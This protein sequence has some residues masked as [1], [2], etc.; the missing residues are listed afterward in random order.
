MI[1][2]I[3]P[4]YSHGKIYFEIFL[5]LFGGGDVNNFILPGGIF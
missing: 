2:K 3:K 5:N 1:V 4:F